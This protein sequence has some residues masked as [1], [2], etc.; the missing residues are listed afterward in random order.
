MVRASRVNAVVWV[1]FMLPRQ[2]WKK[3]KNNRSLHTSS[4]KQQHY[5]G[6]DMEILYISTETL[7]WLPTYK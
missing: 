6:M 4:M 3:R 7:T 2:E 1:Y 5:Q